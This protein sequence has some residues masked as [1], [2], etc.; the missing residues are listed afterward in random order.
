MP[1][2]IY[3]LGDIAFLDA[4]QYILAQKGGIDQASSIHVRFLNDE[5]VLRFVQRIDG[6]PLWNSPLTP[7]DA[8]AATLSPFVFLAVRV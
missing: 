1:H 6:Q 7:A 5:T 8:S 2:N 3:S 4:S